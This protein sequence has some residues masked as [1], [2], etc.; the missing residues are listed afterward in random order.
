ME[1]L[2]TVFAAAEHNSCFP[3]DP[4]KIEEAGR[5]GGS[6]GAKN[7]GAVVGRVI[8]LDRLKIRKDRRQESKDGKNPH[9]HDQDRSP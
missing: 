1:E 5:G 9:D 8:P 4:P 3:P 6:Q 2:C 7:M